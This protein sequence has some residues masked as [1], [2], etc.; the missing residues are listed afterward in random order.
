M[1]SA[2]PVGAFVGPII[3]GPFFDTY[4]LPPLIWANAT[5]MLGLVAL[6]TIGYDDPYRGR[7][8]RPLR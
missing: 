5:A 1:N 2:G 3:G 8:G 6:L 4:G 7:A